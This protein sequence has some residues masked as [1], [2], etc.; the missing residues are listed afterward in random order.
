VLIYCET[1]LQ[2]RAIAVAYCVAFG[3]PTQEGFETG[4]IIGAIEK[5]EHRP[6]IVWVWREEIR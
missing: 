2:Q 1:A 6:E 3:Q 4:T 5:L